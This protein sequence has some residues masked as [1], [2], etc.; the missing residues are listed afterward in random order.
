MWKWNVLDERMAKSYGYPK[1]LDAHLKTIT[2]SI[3]TI[4]LSKVLT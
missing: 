3:L 4:A 1:R 2:F